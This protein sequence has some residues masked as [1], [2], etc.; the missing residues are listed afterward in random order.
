MMVVVRPAP[1]GMREA[2]RPCRNSC[3]QAGTL[4]PLLR[5]RRRVPAQYHVG[6]TVAD[7]RAVRC[8]AASGAV[9]VLKNTGRFTK[10]E[11]RGSS[12]RQG[13]RDFQLFRSQGILPLQGCRQ[14]GQAGGERK[15]FP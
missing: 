6:K 9:C 12:V 4:Q 1:G 2:V 15:V 10:T 5:P 13:Y 8:E 11:C 14:S 3:P 7:D